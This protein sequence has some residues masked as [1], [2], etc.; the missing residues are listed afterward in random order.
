MAYEVLWTRILIFSFSSTVYAFTIILATFLA[1]LALGGA[2]F[3]WLEAR[4]HRVGALAIALIAA[5]VT[6]LVTAP[7]SARSSH[8]IHGLSGWLGFTGSVF[9]AASALVLTSS[10]SAQVR[11]W[12]ARLNR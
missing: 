8:M 12:A 11:S 2:L 3:T 10:G 5:G 6:S 4:G 7:L 1:G 9:L